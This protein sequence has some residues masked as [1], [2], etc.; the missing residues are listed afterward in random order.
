MYA[1]LLKRVMRKFRY[2]QGIPRALVVSSP[3]TVTRRDV[4]IIF[5]VLYDHLVTMDVCRVQ[6]PQIWNAVYDY[7]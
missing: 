1:H 7:I 2:M 6:S 3:P 4:D 5:E